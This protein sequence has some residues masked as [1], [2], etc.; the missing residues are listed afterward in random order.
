M[1]SENQAWILLYL[2]S[3]RKRNKIG[4]LWRREGWIEKNQEG[5]EGVFQSE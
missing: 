1:K 5:G 4:Q 3:R 2:F